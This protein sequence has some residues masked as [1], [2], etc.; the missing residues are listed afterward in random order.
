MS[1]RDVLKKTEATRMGQGIQGG[2]GQYLEETEARVEAGAGAHPR[3]YAEPNALMERVL[4]R[5][6]LMPMC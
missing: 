5:P 3:T 6:N 4:E 2:A 1:S